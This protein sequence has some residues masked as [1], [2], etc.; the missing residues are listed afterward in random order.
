MFGTDNT[1]VLDQLRLA[2]VLLLR[3]LTGTVSEGSQ[4]CRFVSGV[5]AFWFFVTEIRQC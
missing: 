3:S 4:G 2:P 5:M 1:R